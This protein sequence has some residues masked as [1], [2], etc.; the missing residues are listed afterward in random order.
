[1]DKYEIDRIKRRTALEEKVTAATEELID[2]LNTMGNEDEVLEFLFEKITHSHRTLQ[3]NF[4][5]LIKGFLK[6][7]GKL[8]YFDARNQGAVDYAKT[9]TEAA[10]KKPIPFI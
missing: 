4:V 5:R 6:Q 2:S 3:A 1:M 8:E 9:A 10:E 7:Y